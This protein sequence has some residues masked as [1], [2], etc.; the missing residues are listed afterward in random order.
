MLWWVVRVWAEDYYALCQS[1]ERPK[2]AVAGPFI[3]R[4]EARAAYSRLEDDLLASYL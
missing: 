3:C 4:E 1:D 2:L